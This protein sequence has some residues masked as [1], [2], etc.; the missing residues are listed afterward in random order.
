MARRRLGFTLIELLVVIAIIAILAAILFPVFLKAKESARNTQCLSNARQIGLAL[1]EYAG[2]WNGNIPALADGARMS[3]RFGFIWIYADSLFPYVKNYGVFI[4]PARI[5]EQSHIRENWEMRNILSYGTNS[6]VAG[7]GLNLEEP[8]TDIAQI[9]SPSRK[10]LMGEIYLGELTMR[11]NEL[12]RTTQR[13]YNAPI[14][15]LHDGRPIWI[16]AD[17]HAKSMTPR[18]T[19]E[20]TFMW[21]LRDKY[22]INSPF[23]LMNSEAQYQSK[24]TRQLRLYGL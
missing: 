20:P 8:W 15:S 11:M 7:D 19:V 3:E 14:N 4:C 13:Y 23:G 5:D 18:R 12:Y 16:F 17:G 1:M 2:N 10:I 21:N 24:I 22:P 6:Y 9:R